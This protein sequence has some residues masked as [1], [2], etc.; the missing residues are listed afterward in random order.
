M[1]INE[2]VVILSNQVSTIAAAIATATAL[3]NLDQV[4]TLEAK[5]IETQATLDAVKA[6]G[7]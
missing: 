6:I 3:G 1:T 7:G 5:L 2:L 4:I